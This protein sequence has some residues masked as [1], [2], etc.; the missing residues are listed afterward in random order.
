MLG[1]PLV[2]HV[3]LEA[4]VVHAQVELLEALVVNILLVVG[5]VFEVV[6]VHVLLEVLV[7]HALLVMGVLLAANRH[8]KARGGKVKGQGGWGGEGRGGGFLP[9][10]PSQENH[11][12]I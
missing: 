2:V 10:P 11:A 5:E 9:S 6:V 7:V 4:Q 1:E 12:I 8:C 3:V